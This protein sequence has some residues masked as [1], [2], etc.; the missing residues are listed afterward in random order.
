MAD[1]HIPLFPGNH[2]HIFSRAIGSE[3]L[4]REEENFRF[5]LQK[6]EEH[7][8]SVCRIWAYCLIPNHFHLLVEIKNEDEIK[9]AFE[10]AK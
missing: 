4:F 3:I 1:Y 5:F 10:S 6:T 8:L 2:D 7:L 9:Q